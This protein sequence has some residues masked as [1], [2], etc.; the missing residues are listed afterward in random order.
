MN[1]RAWLTIGLAGSAAALGGVGLSIVQTNSR[2]GA[3]STDALWTRNFERPDGGSLSLAPWRGQPIVVNFWATWCPPCVKELPEFER[4]HRGQRESGARV[5]GVALDS[6]APVREFLARVQV[7]FPIGLAGDSG[8]ELVHALGNEQGG[9]PFTV[10]I[11]RD[12]SVGWR[13][14]GATNFEELTRAVGNAG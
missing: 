14:L 3:R 13:K 10:V 4:F 8:F 12:G 6:A 5:V 7:T 2:S 11:H 9:L 1:R